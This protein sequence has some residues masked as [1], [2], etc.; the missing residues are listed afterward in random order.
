MPG[1][2]L[3]LISI[4]QG[5]HYENQRRNFPPALIP[6][7]RFP[8]QCNCLHHIMLCLVLCFPMIMLLCLVTRKQ[9]NLH[10]ILEDDKIFRHIFLCE[11][12]QLFFMSAYFSSL[13]FS[14]PWFAHVC[15]S[16]PE[17]IFSSFF[18]YFLKQSKFPPQ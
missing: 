13:S 11:F 6:G 1:I 2:M 14:F 4:P 5:S 3:A 9:S 12:I 7:M 17:C 18:K 16:Y 10:P 8:G 15:F